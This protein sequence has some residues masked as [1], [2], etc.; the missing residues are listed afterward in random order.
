MKTVLIT[1]CSSGIGRDAALTLRAR[2]WRVIPTARRPGDVAALEAA[3]FEALLLDYEDETS[4]EEAAAVVFA[5]PVDAVVQNGAYAIP[6]FIEDL[7]TDA[8]RTIFEA[9]FLGWHALT[10]HALRHMRAQ[11]R[12]RIVYVSS[13]LGF[14]AARWRGAYCATKFALE[15]YVDAL[16]LELR[17][18][19]VRAIL[20]EPGPIETKFND[21]A[22]AQF[23]RWIDVA[24]SARAE[25][26]KGLEKRYALAGDDG[27]PFMLKPAAVSKRIVHALESPGP[28][29]RYFV[30]APTWAAEALRRFAPRAFMDWVMARN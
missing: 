13:V 6:G 27:R 12:G 1:G 30:T 26:Y 19:P 2:G 14:S 18:S 25:D 17:D 29:D 15:G 10:R 4:I 8:M 22:L 28:C 20:V 3:G 11:G 23:K 16:R 24:Q 9:N 5:Q 21:N 7:P